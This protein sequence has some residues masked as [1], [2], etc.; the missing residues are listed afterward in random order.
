MKLSKYDLF[1]L[2]VALDE[3]A[4]LLDGDGHSVVPADY[5]TDLAVPSLFIKPLTRTIKSDFRDHKTTIYV[6]GK[7]VK[8]FKGIWNLDFLYSVA[9][10]LG[11]DDGE[12]INKHGRGTQARILC[13]AIRKALPK[14]K[15]QVAHSL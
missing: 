2:I 8:S 5:Y 14:L 6:K 4:E 11:V 13:S 7:P 12:A 3:N 9:S 15:I 10:T 1:D